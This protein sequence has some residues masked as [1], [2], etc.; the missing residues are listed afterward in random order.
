MA[1]RTA[2]DNGTVHNSKAREERLSRAEVALRLQDEGLTRA[3]IADRMGL[4]RDTVKALLRDAKFHRSPTDNPERLRVAR[5]ARAALRTS[6]RRAD[7][8]RE[9]GL[10]QEKAV[11][12]WRDARARSPSFLTPT[13]RDSHTGLRTRRPP[14]LATI[15]HLALFEAH[16]LSARQACAVHALVSVEASNV[17]STS[18]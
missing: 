15:P 3:Q 16:V 8:A 2:G 4:G 17:A 18:P 11:E 1:P 10:S 9:H 13:T 12:A 7:F 6:R 5:D 14:C